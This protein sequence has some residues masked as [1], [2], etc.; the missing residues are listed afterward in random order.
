MERLYEEDDG[1]ESYSDAYDRERDE[2]A[3][4]WEIL[5][6]LEESWPR[7][8][9]MGLLTRARHT[10]DRKADRETRIYS[11]IVRDVIEHFR[12]TTGWEKH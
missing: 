3:Y 1:G 12:R 8:A 10:F 7:R 6:A 11:V 9:R 5:R 2:L 4:E